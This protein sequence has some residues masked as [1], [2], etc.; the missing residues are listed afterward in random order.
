MAREGRAQQALAQ[1]AAGFCLLDGLF[2]DGGLG[3]IFAADID[4]PLTSTHGI[5]RNGH[6]FEDLVRVGL[7]QHAILEDQGF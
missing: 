7:Q 5:R 2:Q 3:G 6:A 4:Y 1:I